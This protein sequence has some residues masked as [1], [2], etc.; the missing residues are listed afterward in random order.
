MRISDWS[1][2][3]CSSDLLLDQPL[4]KVVF[5]PQ[6]VTLVPIESQHTESYFLTKIASMAETQGLKVHNA[7]QGIFGLRWAGAK[8]VKLTWL[9]S[10]DRIWNHACSELI[11]GG[12]IS[13][14]QF[15]RALDWGYVSTL[16]EAEH[17]W[18]YR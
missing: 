12:S 6:G 7:I 15:R 17:H 18:V 11:D 16:P 13:L 9:G 3:V 2:D 14:R 5:E 10:D 8:S 4:T 1:S